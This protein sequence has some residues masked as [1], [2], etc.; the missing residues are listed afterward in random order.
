MGYC[1]GIDLGTTFTAAAIIR[2]G[3]PEMA[4]LGSRTA[5]VPTV[6]FVADDGTEILV[7]EAARRR[8]ATDPGRVA[9][10]FKRRLG[11]STPIFLGDTPRSPESLLALVLRWVVDQVTQQEGGPPDRVV[12]T[13]PANWGA[14][15][16]ELLEHAI[17]QSDVANVSTDHRARGGRRVLRVG[18]ADRARRADLRLRPRR[19]HVR[20]RPPAQDRRPG[21]SSSAT[22]EGIEH[23]GGIDVDEAIFEHV[24]RSLGGVLEG[25]DPDDPQA[26]RALHRLREECTEAKE[27]LSYDAGATV[28]VLLPGV[29]SEVVITRSELEPMIRPLLADTIA[30]LR[31]S[32]ATAGVEPAQVRA[33]LLVGGTSRIPLVAEMIT[34]ELGRPVA[35]DAHPKHSIAL[36]A[37]LT[38]A[39]SSVSGTPGVDA[40]EA[41]AAAV[42][43]PGSGGRPHR[44][45]PG[46]TVRGRRWV[47]WRRWSAQVAHPR[48]RRR[49]R[50]RHRRL[51]PRQR[52]RRRRRW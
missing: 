38:A 47:G 52:G 30:A 43:E 24:R 27:A 17:R 2:D 26:V 5:A 29:Q 12:V 1:L 19:R 22:P 14:Y 4:V 23:L 25:L 7:G 20:R 10:E 51:P 9:R 40:T 36:G 8:V 21:S 41:A 46:G 48:R 50:S 3:R 49:R 11:D 13:H 18:R 37:A 31:R 45:D 44:A 34:A 15:R 39:G 35:V 6:I 32:F 33:V 16:K 42:P 28:P